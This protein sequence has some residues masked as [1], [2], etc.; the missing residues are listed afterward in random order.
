M[1]AAIERLKEAITLHEG[2]RKL[3]VEDED[4]RPLWGVVGELN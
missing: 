4:L 1:D 3:A 2:I